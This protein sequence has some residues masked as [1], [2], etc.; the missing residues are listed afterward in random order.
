MPYPQGYFDYIYA[1]LVL[2]YLPRSALQSALKELYRVLRTNG[3]I[4]VVVRSIDCTEA[5]EKSSR[6]D[7]HSGLTTYVSDGTS[8]ARYFH[9]EESIQNHLTLAGFSIKHV[10]TYNEKLCIDFERTMPAKQI[11]SLIELLAIKL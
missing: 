7:A 10:N 1:R 2:H 6:F 4:F 8:Y 3:K 9:S 11:D 5:R